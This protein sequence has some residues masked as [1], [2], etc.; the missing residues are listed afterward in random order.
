MPQDWSEE[1]ISAAY[2]LSAQT[3]EVV[4]LSQKLGWT[5][6][7]F[8]QR[9]E[10]DVALARKHGLEVFISID[11]LEDD[12]KEIAQLPDK[13]QGKGFSDATLRQYYID[14]VTEIADRYRPENLALAIEINGYHLSH[15]EDFPNYVSLYKQAFR[16]VKSVSPETNVA[17]SFQYETMVGEGQWDL[18]S[19]F[20][21][22]LEMLCL[23][24][25]PEFLYG[26]SLSDLPD[27]HYSILENIGT[28]PTVFM[29]IG[30]RGENS[31]DGERQQAEFI[32]RFFDLTAD[33]NLSLG[34]WALLHD[35][36]GGGIFETMGLIDAKGRKK[37]AWEVVRAMHE[38]PLKQ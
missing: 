10:N 7:E 38:L 33:I 23:T 1:N 4:S 26:D 25:Y 8:L 16:S 22:Q 21:G 5:S 2:Q 12:R 17:V 34:I 31:E 28:L 37:P 6:D 24:T 3:G 18:L 27:N 19:M 9:Y 15:P 13:L 32:K 11:V 29:E 30:W 14:E 36:Q 20:G 35:W